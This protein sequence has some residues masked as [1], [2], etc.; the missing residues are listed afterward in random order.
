M[1][2]YGGT[3]A[4]HR[5]D[6]LLIRKLKEW[7]FVAEEDR[8]GPSERRVRSREHTCPPAHVTRDRGYLH[9][10]ACVNVSEETH[11]R[12]STVHWGMKTDFLH[13][14]VRSLTDDAQ[15]YSFSPLSNVYAACRGEEM[16]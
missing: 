12:P 14:F 7:S 9:G 3:T 6:D 10:G 8:T 1:V 16:H 2:R 15:R 13:S 5:D 11:A 4:G